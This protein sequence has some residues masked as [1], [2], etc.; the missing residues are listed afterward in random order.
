MKT[1]N[2][3]GLS[4]LASGLAFVGTSNATDIIIDGSYESATNNLVTPIIG[5]G[6]NDTAGIDGEWTHISTYSY[7]AGYT[8]AAPAGA[9]RV[10]LP[11]YNDTGGSTIVSQTNSLS[12]ALSGANIDAGIGQYSL[13]AWFSTYR[14]QNDY[15]V[16]TLQFLD[17]SLAS[18]GS[19][20]QI[21]GA[22]FVASLPGGGGLRA[23][24]R[25]AT[26]GAV[27]TGARYA[28]ITTAATALVNLPD[29]YVDLVQ[30][31]ISTNA[32]ISVVSTVPSD[33]AS[34]VSPGVAVRVVL[35]DGAP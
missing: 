24:G 34:D 16:L 7:S 3:L 21:G 5:N 4:I 22:A 27:A 28:A 14:G 11:P 35:Q 30:L 15:S 32:T 18:V 12:R 23:W 20:I 31:D 33:A 26:A 10:Y 1:S 25:D 2:T 29:G 8:Q 6:G 9:G 19:P 13:S 17:G